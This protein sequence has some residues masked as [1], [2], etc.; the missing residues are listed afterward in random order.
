MGVSAIA[1]EP[2]SLEECGLL[3]FSDIIGA[4]VDANS[5]QEKGCTGENGAK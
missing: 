3:P 5:D 4:V 1:C 2:Q